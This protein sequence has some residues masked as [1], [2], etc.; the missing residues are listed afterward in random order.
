MQKVT[1]ASIQHALEHGSQSM[2][3]RHEVDVQDLLPLLIRS[4]GT[5]GH[6]DAGVGA[7]KIHG[8]KL[9]GC[10]VDEFYH[11]LTAANITAEPGST[12]RVGN[13]VRFICLASPAMLVLMAEASLENTLAQ[14][15]PALSWWG[16][17]GL[18]A[19]LAAVAARRRDQLRPRLEG[20][21][22]R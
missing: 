14:P 18:I 2:H 16:A 22:E 15:V 21:R 20:S 19:G 10:V 13:A 11:R 8:A 5:S 12:D 17:L 1:T 6:G 9:R 4:F 7:E 3:V